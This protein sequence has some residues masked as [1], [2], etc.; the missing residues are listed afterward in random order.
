MIKQL[1]TPPANQILSVKESATLAE[2]DIGTIRR[3]IK[4]GARGR[5]LPAVWAGGQMV[6][7]WSDLRA[8]LGRLVADAPRELVAV[9]AGADDAA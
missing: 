8:F 5:K 9:G 4:R 6:V 3:W 2:V 1:I 7:L